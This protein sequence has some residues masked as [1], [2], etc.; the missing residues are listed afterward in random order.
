MLCN[1]LVVWSSNLSRLVSDKLDSS[2]PLS[3]VD[4]SLNSLIEDS[5]LDVSL[6]GKVKLLLTD[7]PVTP[8]F[9]KVNDMCWESSSSMVNSFPE[10]VAS[11]IRVHSSVSNIHLLE[12][13]SS[14]LVHA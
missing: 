11:D 4:C 7:K 3:S 9:L 12:E 10:G 8:L 6:D 2:V 13:I 5:S 14:F 1:L